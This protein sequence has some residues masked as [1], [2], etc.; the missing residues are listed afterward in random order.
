ML[1]EKRDGKGLGETR[2]ASTLMLRLRVRVRKA[3]SL[4][5]ISG[6]VPQSMLERLGR[7]RREREGARRNEQGHAPGEVEST[8]LPLSN[9]VAS[10]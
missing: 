9:D 6:R 7:G 10:A 5:A 1:D 4:S 2:G 8:S 3:R